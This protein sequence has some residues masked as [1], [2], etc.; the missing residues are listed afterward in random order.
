MAVSTVPAAKTKLVEIFK[1]AVESQTEV[2]RSRPNEDHQDAEN[3]YVGNT[4]GQREYASIGLSKPPKRDET[5]T[6]AHA[7][8]P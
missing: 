3:V 7:S 6:I 8:S 1:A 4:R 5:Y 2:W